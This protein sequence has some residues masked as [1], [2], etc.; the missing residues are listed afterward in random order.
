MNSMERVK[1]NTERQHNYSREYKRYDLAIKY[2][3][4]LEAVAISYAII[5]DRLVSMLHY[6]GIV[7]RDN[8]TLKV[9]KAVYPFLRCLL[10]RTGN[11]SIQVKNVSVKIMLIEK[12]LEMNEEKAAA[13]DLYVKNYRAESG[14]RGIAREGYMLDLYQQINRT[15]NKEKVIALLDDFDAWAETRNKLTHALFNNTAESTSEAKESCAK[16]GYQLSRRFDNCIADPFKSKNTL[17][18]K[19]KI[20]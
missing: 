9:N 15:L 3:F 11:A 7:S 16:M 1:T 5:E 2:G 6:A 4:Y 10:G 18:K 14:K 13:I 17:R 19:Y 8:E 12:L 20:Q